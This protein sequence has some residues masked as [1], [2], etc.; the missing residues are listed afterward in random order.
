MDL[1]KQQPKKSTSISN[2]A[3]CSCSVITGI[4]PEHYAVHREYN[5]KVVT[6]FCVSTSAYQPTNQPTTLLGFVFFSLSISLLLPSL[7]VHTIS[8]SSPYFEFHFIYLFLFFFMNLMQ[9]ISG[10]YLL[11]SEA[12]F[13][14]ATG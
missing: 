14:C 6:P 11:T 12:Y 13:N 5:Q 3:T 1:C 2:I 8:F 9:L 10:L 4:E 7:C